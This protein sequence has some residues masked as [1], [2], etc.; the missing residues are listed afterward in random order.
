V[1]LAVSLVAV[2]AFFL[3]S[4]FAEPDS[5]DSG[6]PATERIE[7]RGEEEADRWR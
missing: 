4:G 2:L 7:G 3:G 1:L 6:S 5:G